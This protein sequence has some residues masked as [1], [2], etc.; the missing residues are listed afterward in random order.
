[1]ASTEKAQ[2]L[3][4][5]L[6]HVEAPQG[7]QYVHIDPEIERRVVRKLDWNLIPLVMALCKFSSRRTSSCTCSFSA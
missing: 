3:D 2:E 4:H 7:Y 1:M 5:E 6:E